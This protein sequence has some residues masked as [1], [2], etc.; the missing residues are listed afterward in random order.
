[1]MGNMVMYRQSQCLQQQLRDYMLK[2]MK[3]TRQRELIGKVWAFETS[4]HTLMTYILQKGQALHGVPER[5]LCEAVKV[6]PG[7]HQSPQD[8]GNV[9]AVR[10][11]PRRALDREWNQAKKEKCAVGS[12]AEGV[13]PSK[14]TDIRH[15]AIGFGVLF[16]GCC[17]LVSMSSLC[18]HFFFLEWYYRFCAF[19]CWK[20][21]ICL[22][23]SR[24]LQRRDWIGLSQK[25]ACKTLWGLLKLTKCVLH[26]DMTMTLWRPGN[27]MWWSK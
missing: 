24:G 1:M 5:P 26:Y 15:K 27:G 4:Q 20:Y 7:L 11:W 13:G 2:S 8:V 17:S 9:R 14:S 3:T 12:Q 6:K 25:T 23:F 10:H 19:A 16:A 21:V 18:P 22:L